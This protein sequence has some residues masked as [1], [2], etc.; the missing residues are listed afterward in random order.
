MG[1]GHH[2]TPLEA[3]AQAVGSAAA[4]SIPVYVYGHH[5]TAALDTRA[6]ANVISFDTFH[7]L[8]SRH[9][10]AIQPSQHAEILTWTG[11]ASNA[12]I[13]GEVELPIKIL[14]QLRWHRCPTVPEVWD[15]EQ[16]IRFL[17]VDTPLD[18]LYVG[19]HQLH[20]S[21]STCMSSFFSRMNDPLIDVTFPF[22]LGQFYSTRLYPKLGEA[23]SPEWASH[24]VPASEDD[25]DTLF[26]SRSLRTRDDDVPAA[27]SSDRGLSAAQ[28]R[29]L[30]TRPPLPSLASD[31]N[32]SPT[33]SLAEVLRSKECQTPFS[34]RQQA[35]AS[36]VHRNLDL[37]STE[38]TPGDNLLPEVDIV[39]QNGVRPNREGEWRTA[40]P[41]VVDGVRAKITEGI[42]KGQLEE[43]DGPT[44]NPDLFVNAFVTARKRD[45]KI[46]F[47]LDLIYVNGH[48]ERH[49]ISLPML[50]DIPTAFQGCGIF[51]CMD[52]SDWFFAFK[53]TEHSHNFCV[54]KFEG[55]YYRFVSVPQGYC[56]IPGIAQQVIQTIFAPLISDVERAIFRAFID[57]L[58][59]GTKPAPGVPLPLVPGTPS[60]TEACDRHLEHLA[61]VFELLARW[62]VRLKPGKCELMRPRA[63]SLGLIFVGTSVSID[64]DRLE[65]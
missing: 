21:A 25:D 4:F 22:K 35:L 51:S 52:L 11:K 56:N 63:R 64:P 8:P 43:C 39:M 61:K 47:V 23:F 62:G 2:Q 38:V 33:S 59:L 31:G 3:T 37:F 9:R 41:K 10:P 36:L 16:T 19:A 15:T 1:N 7:S 6:N 48:C 20:K 5:V 58:T 28:A 55:K 26:E 12:L 54:F 46:R 57:D 27:V 13:K 42:R 60:A 50:H 53:L 34:D 29:S 44:V 40:N 49:A 14:A 45:G 30:G 24:L 32:I 18:F 17:V 65:G